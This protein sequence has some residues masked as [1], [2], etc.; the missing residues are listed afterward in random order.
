ME[1]GIG[2]DDVAQ[3]ARLE[4]EG[5]RFELRQSLA[6]AEPR[7]LTSLCSVLVVGA[8]AGELR[9]ILSVAGSRQEPLDDLTSRELFFLGG[10]WR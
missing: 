3:L 8:L 4:S 2:P 9:E 6:A 10:V 1:A 5:R 7:Q